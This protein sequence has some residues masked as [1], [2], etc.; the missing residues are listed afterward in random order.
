MS[1]CPYCYRTIGENSI[2]HR[3]PI[4]LIN[5]SKYYWSDS[6]E[7]TL[8]EISDITDRFY[9]GFY[10]INIQ[11]VLELQ[12]YLKELEIDL[13]AEA[14][15]T[16][17]TSF[18]STGKFQILGIHIK[19]MRESI[20]K[21][22]GITE[23]TTPVER[24]SILT[25]FFNYD[26]EGNHITHPNGDKTEWT[27]YI[28]Q[29]HQEDWNKFQIKG[30]HIEDLRHILLSEME[31]FNLSELGVISQASPNLG[32]FNGDIGYKTDIIIDRP[33]NSEL[34]PMNTVIPVPIYLD[35][36]QDP[37]TGMWFSPAN[38]NSNES[39]SVATQAEIKNVGGNKILSAYALM[40]GYGVLTQFFPAA[41]GWYP[42]GQFFWYGGVQW[43]V[44]GAEIDF[45]G[46]WKRPRPIVTA[47]KIFTFDLTCHGAR[48]YVNVTYP[49]YPSGSDGYSEFHVPFFRLRV[50]LADTEEGSFASGHME[51]YLISDISTLIDGTFTIDLWNLFVQANPTIKYV[52]HVEIKLG[53]P[54]IPASG[55]APFS[56]QNPATLAIEYGNIYLDKLDNV[57]L[58]RA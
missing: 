35:P 54:E 44:P 34:E 19:E 38:S 9:K 24:V 48:N 57:G 51:E 49:L 12:D 3:D 30:I 33:W 55:V 5:G 13:L 37:G 28:D 7:T 53:L 20:E 11:E 29:D 25:G 21:M 46:V 23:S 42:T 52:E 43:Y 32:T 58:K 27:D 40:A 39:V 36:V 16:T 45:I 22:L 10:Q 2:W 31:K 8:I 26:E 1:K 6:N 17:F 15:R 14:D 56:G 4:L 41:N 18:N 50:Y 47:N